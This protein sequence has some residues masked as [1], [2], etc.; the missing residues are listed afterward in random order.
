MSRATIL[1]APGELASGRPY[2]ERSDLEPGWHDRLA[3]RLL[4][5]VRPAHNLVRNP[6]RGLERIVGYAGR[7]DQA[8]RAATDSDLALRARSMGARLRREGFLPALV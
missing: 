5:V 4:G 2:A 1:A 3:E 6:A 7:H 8:M